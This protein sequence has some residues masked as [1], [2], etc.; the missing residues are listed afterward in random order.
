LADAIEDISKM[1]L[2][3]M[4]QRGREWMQQEFSWSSIAAAMM[5]TYKEMLQGCTS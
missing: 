5:E 2:E 1:P 3:K 4:G